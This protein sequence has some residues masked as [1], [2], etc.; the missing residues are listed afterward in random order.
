MKRL[1]AYLTI[2]AL[3]VASA[4]CSAPKQK[5]IDAISDFF[6]STETE[7]GSVQYNSASKVIEI[8][9]PLEG[10]NAILTDYL[11]GDELAIESWNSIK[12]VMPEAESAI[13]EY[14]SGLGYSASISLSFADP[15]SLDKPLLTSQN[16]AI[17]YEATE[18]PTVAASASLSGDPYEAVALIE[19]FSPQL[20]TDFESYTARYNETTGI[21]EIFDV[22]VGIADMLENTLAGASGN[23][24][25]W[26]STREALITNYDLFRTLLQ[27]NDYSIP[28]SLSLSD[29]KEPDKPL[30]TAVDGEIVYDVADSEI[31][32]ASSGNPD[33]AVAALEEFLKDMQS[34]YSMYTVHYNEATGTIEVFNVIPGL[35]RMLENTLAG[36]S[37][38]SIDWDSAR[39]GAICNSNSFAA[40]ASSRGYSGPVSLSFSDG[41]TPDV[42]LLTAVNGEIVYDVVE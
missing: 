29:S 10:L 17:V 9:A 19:D 6:A 42:P 39:Q 7:L 15:E 38:G 31:A 3:V 22:F 25:D 36:E 14:L 11:N 8:V 41:E 35:S 12:A 18:V 34:D 30:L 20:K 2:F 21:I 16:G 4:G 40:V 33:G 32:V 27:D 23:S 28:F 5:E 37:A 1:L 13:L 26:N 24:I